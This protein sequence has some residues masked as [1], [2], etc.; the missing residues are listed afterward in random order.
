MYLFDGNIFEAVNRTPRTALRNEY[1]L[2][3]SIQLFIDSGYNV[4]YS[5]VIKDDLNITFLKDL[6]D[7][8]M[9]WLKNHS[10]NVALGE[11]VDIAENVELNDVVV[12]NDAKLEE[13]VILNNT[14]VL[15]EVC[16]K[17]GEKIN[18]SIVTKD[19]ILKI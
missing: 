17:T 3:D 5:N 9:A 6:Y 19:N 18:H 4:Y 1:E 2:T 13:N 16:I 8:N 14:L 11:N 15:S 12:G 10:K 7:I